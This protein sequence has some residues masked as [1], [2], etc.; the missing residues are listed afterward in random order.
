[1]ANKKI[2]FAI[3]KFE[4]MKDS[5]NSQLAKLKLFVCREGNNLH[6]LPISWETIKDA[7]PTLVGKPVLFKYDPFFDDFKSHESDEIACGVFLRSEDISEEIDD[8]GNRWLVSF[9]YLWAKYFPE[10]IKIP[11]FT[12]ITKSG[13]W[14]IT[15]PATDKTNWAL[16]SSQAGAYVEVPFEG[17]G[18]E[19]ANYGANV[20][21]FNILINGVAP[22]TLIK[23]YAVIG[24]QHLNKPYHIIVNDNVLL[25]SEASKGVYFQFTSATEYE[26]RR[27]DNSVLITTGDINTD[28][29]TFLRVAISKN[30]E[31]IIF[32]SANLFAIRYIPVV[33]LAD[34]S[35]LP[36]SVQN[37]TDPTAIVSIAAVSAAVLA[38]LPI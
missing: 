15:N 36:S 29:I 11:D 21:V 35:T 16:Q 2:N 14:S 3:D 37:A 32:P 22:S 24:G 18:I 30:G 26:I 9:A 13:T 8:E 28:P 6:D 20:G 33:T 7:S 19:L 17:I 31:K 23:D 12:K 10:V 27:T 34:F 38:L 1:L 4:L 25:N 5:E